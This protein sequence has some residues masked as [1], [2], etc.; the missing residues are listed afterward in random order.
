[1]R[2]PPLPIRAE[3]FPTGDAIIDAVHGYWRTK[4][5]EPR[6]PDRRD[7]DPLELPPACL[8][9]LMLWDVEANGYRCRLAGTAIVD[10]HGRELRGITTRDLHG[11]ANAKIEAEY[12]WVVRTRQPHFVD[13]AMSWYHRDYTR[14]R[15]LLLPLTRGG[16]AVAVLLS[17]ATYRFAAR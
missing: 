4:C 14:Y 2:R 9:H 15:R 10:V 7:I 16:D 1:M 12:D 11:K 3:P 5:Q 6:I 13:R 17:V 8:P